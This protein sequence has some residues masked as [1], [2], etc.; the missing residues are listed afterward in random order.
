MHKLSKVRL[1]VCKLKGISWVIRFWDVLLNQI[2]DYPQKITVEHVMS[3]YTWTWF[4]QRW[5]KRKLKTF[6][7][8]RDHF[9]FCIEAIY[10]AQAEI[11]EINILVKPTVFMV[12]ITI[13]SRAAGF[14][15]CCGQRDQAVFFLL[16]LNFF[17]QPFCYHRT[18]LKTLR[19]AWARPKDLGRALWSGDHKW[20]RLSVVLSLKSIL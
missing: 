9:V 20:F 14:C 12:K 3:V 2:W 11:G 13:I 19:W 1:M 6:M 8:W 7:C 17:T 5:W 16:F 10:K 4:Y 15:C 18:A